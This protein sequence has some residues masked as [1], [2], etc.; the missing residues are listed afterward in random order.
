M[1]SLDESRVEDA[2]LL[3]D[4]LVA[5]NEYTRVAECKQNG[6]DDGPCDV[7]VNEQRLGCVAHAGALGLRV[8]DDRLAC[9]RSAQAS[10]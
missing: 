8:D 2:C 6:L 1:T 9:S 3:E 7:A 5:A 10:T 4:T